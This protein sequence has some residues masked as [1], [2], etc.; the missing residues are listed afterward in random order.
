MINRKIYENG[1]NMAVNVTRA[2]FKFENVAI[3]WKNGVLTTGAT[4]RYMCLLW[5]RQRAYCGRWPYSS[6][7][8]RSSGDNISR[9][10]LTIFKSNVLIRSRTAHLGGADCSTSNPNE[11]GV[12]IIRM[13][14]ALF[15][16]WTTVT[17]A[18]LGKLWPP[19]GTCA[20]YKGV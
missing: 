4:C 14:I 8:K 1:E 7:V 17:V 3:L 20:W 9:Q 13:K 11:L 18:R 6:N 19:A 16:Y 15:S 2:N 12:C 5:V 10:S